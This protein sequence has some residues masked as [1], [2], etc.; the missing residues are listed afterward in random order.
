[1]RWKGFS[2]EEREAW[3]ATPEPAVGAAAG[4]AA[5]LPTLAD[6]AAAADAARHTP[7]FV[8]PGHWRLTQVA[9]RGE[10]R[11]DGIRSIVRRLD[12]EAPGRRLF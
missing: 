9:P 1:M 10:L 2:L 8:D 12:R 7:G 4:A 11:Q 6:V 5:P 3:M